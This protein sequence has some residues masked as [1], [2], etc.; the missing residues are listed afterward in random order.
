M[1]RRSK[2]VKWGFFAVALAAAVVLGG[3]RWIPFEQ[4]GAAVTSAMSEN[5]PHAVFSCT[6]SRWHFPVGLQLDGFKVEFKSGRK[7]PLEAA[8][9][10]L[11]PRILELLF[12]RLSLLSQAKA[13]GGQLD[14]DID[15]IK[16]FA[17]KGPLRAKISASGIDLQQCAYVTTTL[18]SPLKGKA[19]GTIEYTGDTDNLLGGAGQGHFIIKDADFEIPGNVSGLTGIR[20]DSMDVEIAFQDGKMKV[21]RLVLGGPNSLQS[22]LKGYIFLGETLEESQVSLSGNLEMPALINTKLHFA[23]TG[24]LSKPVITLMG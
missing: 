20:F 16:Y 7:G 10:I 24:T 13:Y 22:V 1:M 6:G 15:Y 19:K 4:I 11:K 12:G 3:Y 14:C 2:T 23:V 17:M 18:G 5:S 8:A 9:L 21:G